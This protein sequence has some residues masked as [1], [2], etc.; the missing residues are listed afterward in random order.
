MM[1]LGTGA[2][3]L[4][5]A[6]GLLRAG[7]L[8]AFPTETVYGLGADASNPEAVA[9]IFRAKGR[10]ADHPIIVHL[11]RAG[12]LRHWARDVPDAAWRLADMFW[13]GPLTLVLQRSNC[14][15]DAI[16]GGQETVGL[17]VPGN[18][19]ALELL[20]AFDGALA[21][22]SANRFGHISPTTAAHVLEAFRGDEVAAV[23]DGGPCSV[24]VEST[25]VDLSGPRARL[26]RHGMIRIEAIEAEL[27]APLERVADQQGPR[28]SGRLQSHYAPGAPVELVD[29][30]ALVGRAGACAAAGERVAVLARREAP[31]NV[32]NPVWMKCRGSRFSSPGRCT[33]RCAAP[34]PLILT[35]SW[36]R[37]RRVPTA[38]RQLPTGFPGRPPPGLIG[39]EASAATALW[40]PG[41]VR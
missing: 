1:R 33:R 31:S 32:V 38:G 22:P 39:T 27:G 35:V 28:A 10:P 7:R 12:D 26:L 2:D 14:V 23:V 25:I 29:A 19:V 40:T 18:K 5:R 11:P 37:Q 21:A 13:P 9:G 3:D 6:A 8:V 30:D 20:R 24:G 34:I 15:C 17:R 41:R 16:T 36:S 4:E